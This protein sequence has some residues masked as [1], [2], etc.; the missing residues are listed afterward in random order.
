VSSLVIKA[1]GGKKASATL[2]LLKGAQLLALVQGMD[3]LSLKRMPSLLPLANEEEAG[4]R[5]H[6]AR[7]SVHREI[8]QWFFSLSKMPNSTDENLLMPPQNAY[9]LTWLRS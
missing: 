7:N 6:K 8:G 9:L 5:Y 1:N 2:K 4:W 3:G